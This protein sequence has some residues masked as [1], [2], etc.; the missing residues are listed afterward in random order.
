[1][2][3]LILRKPTVGKKARAIAAQLNEGMRIQVCRVKRCTVP[4]FLILTS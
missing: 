1:M 4:L 3:L 2:T